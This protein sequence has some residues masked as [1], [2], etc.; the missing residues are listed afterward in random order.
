[1]CFPGYTQR[2]VAYG[3]LTR[4]EPCGFLFHTQRILTAAPTLSNLKRFRLQFRPPHPHI[5]LMTSWKRTPRTPAKTK[6]EVRE[7]LAEAVRNT[8]P[9]IQTKPLPKAKRARE[10]NGTH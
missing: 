3:K 5:L 8:Q 10:P 4:P 2:S 7:M 9:E 6:D 1:M